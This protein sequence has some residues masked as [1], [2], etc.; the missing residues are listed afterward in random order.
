MEPSEADV[1]FGLSDTLL[2]LNE[3]K[4]AAMK[5]LLLVCG[6]VV[7]VLFTIL[8]YVL[9]WIGLR[10]EAGAIPDTVIVSGDEISEPAREAIGKAITLRPNET[11]AYFSSTGV[12]NWEEDGNLI[13][14]QRVVSYMQD[15]EGKFIVEEADY[16]NIE[17]IAPEFS[18]KWIDDTFVWI[19]PREGEE[20]LIALSIE[21]DLDHPAVE[22]IQRKLDEAK[23]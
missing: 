20:F 15:E 9:M 17:E 23:Q 11:I 4:L 6:I 5:N 18:D 12:L 7:G 10:A 3:G 22:Y 2:L 1:R 13:T 14:N 21:E 8:F 19:T 16:D